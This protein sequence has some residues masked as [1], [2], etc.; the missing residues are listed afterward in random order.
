MKKSSRFGIISYEVISD[1][2]LSTNA[3]AIY[4]VLAVHCNKKRTCFPS[5][6]TM[7]DLLNVSYST[8]KRGIKEL[9]Q[10]NYINRNG[11]LITLIK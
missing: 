1:P 2:E 9:K 11:K 4:A 7:A 3:K 8:I 6:G 10:A 5:N